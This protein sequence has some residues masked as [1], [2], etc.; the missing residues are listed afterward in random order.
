MIRALNTFY[1][2]KFK[3][4]TNV[5]AFES[6]IVTNI[7]VHKKKKKKE[8]KIEKRIA[9][10]IIN[11]IVG[12]DRRTRIIRLDFYRTKRRYCRIV[13]PLIGI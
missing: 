13:R 11:D 10:P 8:K 12:L 9:D 4:R 2:F 3:L 7:F 1:R 5:R 6:L